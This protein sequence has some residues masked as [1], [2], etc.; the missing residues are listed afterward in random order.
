MLA[1]QMGTV[2]FGCIRTGFAQLGLCSAFV[3]QSG[4]LANLVG[5]PGSRGCVEIGGCN[6]FHR[7]WSAYGQSAF[8]FC[9]RASET[10]I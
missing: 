7:T 8:T 5:H 2:A 3:G 1:T 9:I 4:S 10:L 6:G